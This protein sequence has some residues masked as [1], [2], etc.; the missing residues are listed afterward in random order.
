M[1]IST[2]NKN[3]SFNRS[4]LRNFQSM[5]IPIV[6]LRVRVTLSDTRAAIVSY[7][8]IDYKMKNM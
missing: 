2:S 4:T 3:D 6:L 7:L 1:P 5:I 8:K